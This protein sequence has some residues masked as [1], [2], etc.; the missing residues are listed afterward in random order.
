MKIEIN[1]EL[2]QWEK[3]RYITFSSSDI[4]P[5]FFCFYNQKSKHGLEVLPDG[6][7][8]Y[9]PDILLQQ[10]IPIIAEACIGELGEG[11]VVKRAFF[12]VLKRAKPENYVDYEEEGY[13]IIYDGGEEV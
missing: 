5:D 9:I 7:K 8:V 3:N 12:K 11:Q 6:N 2:F 1:K 10:A 4:T 13:H